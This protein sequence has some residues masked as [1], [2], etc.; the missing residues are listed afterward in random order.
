MVSALQ[1]FK[2]FIL[3]VRFICKTKILKK[4]QCSMWLHTTE[5]DQN[6]RS[7]EWIKWPKIRLYMIDS[8][9][10]SIFFMFLFD[11]FADLWLKAFHYSTKPFL[12]W[13]KC[14]PLIYVNSS[15]PL[16]AVSEG[17]K[18]FLQSYDCWC[19]FFKAETL[20]F[21]SYMGFKRENKPVL[22]PTDHV[23]SI[24]FCIQ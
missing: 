15:S 6:T 7:S 9:H 13:R 16:D 19:L 21:S 2:F 24:L 12:I 5:A 17:S 20:M 14:F 11:W 23:T 10:Y 4:L 8:N 1:C 22:L 3:V 18:Y